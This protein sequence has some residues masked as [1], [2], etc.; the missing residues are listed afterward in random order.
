MSFVF[1]EM[2]DKKKVIDL[3]INRPLNRMDIKNANFD[4]R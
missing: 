4:E 2:K 1:S 3:L